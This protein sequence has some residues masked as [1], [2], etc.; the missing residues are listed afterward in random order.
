MLKTKA[1][2]KFLSAYTIAMLS[3]SVLLVGL[4]IIIE[5]H[6][7]RERTA[8]A[9]NELCDVVAAND[10]IAVVIPDSAIRVFVF[11]AGFDPIYDSKP[12]DETFDILAAAF[13]R[14]RIE[15]KG[16]DY[17][18]CRVKPEDGYRFYYIK[19]YQDRYV[20]LSHFYESRSDFYNVRASSLLSILLLFT[21]SLLGFFFVSSKFAQSLRNLRDHVENIDGSQ[22]NYTFPDNEFRQISEH[23]N[24]LYQR[25]SVSQN[26]YASEREKLL[27]HLKISKRG[28]AIFSPQRKEILSNDLFIQYINLMSDRRLRNSIEFFVLPEFEEVVDYL[29]SR[30][31]SEDF[32]GTKIF[33]VAKRGYTL[34]VTCILFNDRSFEINIEDVTR[35]Q[36]QETIK[37]ELTQNIS[38][39]LKTPVSSIQ[40]FMEILLNNPDIEPEKRQFYIQR[41]YSQAT[42]LSF[43]LKDISM[44]NKLDSSSDMFDRIPVNLY[45][46]VEGVMQ[47]VAIE[48]KEKDFHVVVT[49]MDEAVVNGNNSLLYSIFRNL[50]DNSLHYAGTG[51]N[52]TINCYRSDSDFYYISY[53]DDGVGVDEQHL[54][55][56]F[57]RFYRV[58][59]GRSRKLG[60]TGLGLAI[61]KNAV[62][63]HGG[64]I[65]VRRFE[66]GGLEFLFT[67]KRG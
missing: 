16:S 34:L 1:N 12:D 49:G 54:S 17:A 61:V 21:G 24:K 3:F 56:L 64:R 26:S 42:R 32:V 58:D 44:L 20:C 59:K 30:Q 37:R 8:M 55:R 47:D 10:T 39:E 15:E 57:E 6:I 4:Q 2:K 33:Y 13:D 27:S 45:D 23:V 62:I 46:L 22:V 36:E 11:D 35:Q 65:S 53:A 48:L 60:G 51:I 29:D 63:W 28:L 38:H 52:V 19:K 18:L 25:V 5:N 7:Q 50:I 66:K 31:R 14:E 43:L 67:L 9:L 40:G 41:C